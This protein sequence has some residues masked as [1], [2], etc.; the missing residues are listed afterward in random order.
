M[1]FLRCIKAGRPCD[2]Y[3]KSSQTDPLLGRIRLIT[4][5]LST[6]PD[7]SSDAE[8]HAFEFYQLVTAPM[9]SY[10]PID[11][12]FW[13]D[14][15]L[16]FCH[17]D[18]PVRHA[19]FALSSIHESMICQNTAKTRPQ[20]LF[21]LE[22][23]NKAIC[24]LRDSIRHGLADP[25]VPLLTT[26]LFISLEYMQVNRKGAFECIVNG[27]RFLSDNPLRNKLTISQLDVIKQHIVPLFA[28]VGAVVMFLGL[29]DSAACPKPIPRGLN[30]FYETPAA[31]LSV[32]QARDSLYIFA[33]EIWQ[34]T[35]VL[36]TKTHELKTRT[37]QD[38]VGRSEFLRRLQQWYAAFV[39]LKLAAPD[40]PYS[41]G[42][43][44]QLEMTYHAT[45][46]ML[47]T[48]TLKDSEEALFDEQLGSFVSII[49]LA[50]RF[51]S[52][53]TRSGTFHEHDTSSHSEGDN[54]EVGPGDNNMPEV[55]MPFSFDVCFISTLFVVAVK[56][57]H[58]IIRRSAL[59]LMYR[60]GNKHEALLDSW[61][62]TQAAARIVQAET[63]IAWKHHQE[64]CLES[65]RGHGKAPYCQWY[66][67]VHPP[68]QPPQNHTPVS[69]DDTHDP[70]TTTETGFYST[71]PQLDEESQLMI[72]A[73]SSSEEETLH[74]L[75]DEAASSNDD[76]G[77]SAQAGEP[78]TGCAVGRSSGS[79]PSAI[80][81]AVTGG[82]PESIQA[83]M[84]DTEFPASW[85]LPPFGLPEELRMTGWICHQIPCAA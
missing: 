62:M 68:D 44:C 73:R 8:S 75:E 24:F 7:I 32:K 25:L 23:Y 77:P 57:R 22:Q 70:G 60:C 79:R 50:A 64:L 21:G 67:Q 49:P 38:S 47:T 55:G 85:L 15:V 37:T 19:V 54:L 36:H 34:Y 84:E 53:M 5:P 45:C 6:L 41:Q 29:P 72:S 3:Q 56:C 51:V 74:E 9:L 43:L 48:T 27:R 78:E 58:P 46:I 17:S 1:S 66:D 39:M 4:R 71:Q 83:V 18:P 80:Q 30:A 33:S 28:R 52:L 63:E 81:G 12:D 61:E 20:P 14:L 26:L 16:Q 35:L 76:W 11:H 2:G 69:S 59:K 40:D 82:E 65:L 10:G 31:F 13:S 42:M